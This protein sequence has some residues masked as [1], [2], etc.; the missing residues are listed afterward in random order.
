MENRAQPFWEKTYRSGSH[1]FSV[2]PSATLKK[3]ER[4]SANRQKSLT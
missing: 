1:T 3:F 4:F 2:E